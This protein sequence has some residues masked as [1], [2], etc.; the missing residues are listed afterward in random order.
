MLAAIDRGTG[1]AI[2]WI[3]GFPLSSAIFEPQLA[4][5][6]RR[7]V[8]PDLP[9]FGATPFD[10]ALPATIDAYADAVAACVRSLGIDRATL[11]GVSM[12]GYV[13][14]A[15]LRRHPDL[16]SSV[17]LI[18][19]REKADSDEGRAGRAAMADAVRRGGA[20]HA[21]D[22][23]FP[24]MLTD[25]THAAADWRAAT[26]RRAMASASVDGIVAALSAMASRSDSTQTLRDTKLPVLAIAGE[27][28][29]ITPPA[30]AERMAALAG[31]GAH[32]VI[33]GAAH[34]SNVESPAEFNRAVLAFLAR[35][36]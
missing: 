19:T 25:A 29:T 7:H 34:L 16:A 2:V 13:V 32:V 12:G 3:H 31:D 35:Q 15:I 30:E 17:I 9:G 1:P 14:F 8:A 23:M 11:A 10:P 36:L 24:K 26:V 18:D 21:V 5:P 20:A 22:P 33:A 6:G 28:D 4:I 27:R